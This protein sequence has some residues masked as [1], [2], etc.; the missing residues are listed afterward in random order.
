[1]AEDMICVDG[2]VRRATREIEQY[3]ETLVSCIAAY[4]ACLRHVQIVG[5]Q[6]EIIRS[7]L[8]RLSQS[9]KEYSTALSE[10]LMDYKN[11][12]VRMMNAFEENDSFV[13][14]NDYVND[15]LILIKMFV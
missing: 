2:E 4:N 7:K 5:I 9:L 15:L 6:D 13:F 1:M 12:G 10:I 3:I 14:P 8:G 11:L